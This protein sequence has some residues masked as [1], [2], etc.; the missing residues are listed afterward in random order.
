M[1]QPQVF[2]TGA[3]GFLGEAVVFRLLL[4]RKFIP[5]AA[6]RSETRLNGLCRIVRWNLSNPYDLV[7]LHDIQVV[8]HCAARVH[9]MKEITSDVLAQFRKIN[10]EGTSQLARHAARSGVKRFIYVSSIKVNGEST[11]PGFPFRALHS[12]APLDPYGV[13]K[14]EAEE[15]LRKISRATGMELVI[16]RP[17]LV[18]GPGVKANFLKMMAWLDKGWILPLGAIHNRRSLVAIDNLVDLIVTCADHPAAAGRTLLVSDDSDLSTTQ[19][20]SAIGGALGRTRTRLLPIPVNILSLLASLL[21][22]KSTVQRLCCS[23]QVDISETRKLLNWSPP[24]NIEKALR[25][26]VAYYRDKKNT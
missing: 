13:S 23:L 5:I 14:W 21:G 1:K 4:D 22:Q 18:Y 15:E 8:I 6:V 17:P 20:L 26:T 9:V 16:I 2:V 19:L 25:R 7:P 3:A 10:V 24:V 11:A 12:P